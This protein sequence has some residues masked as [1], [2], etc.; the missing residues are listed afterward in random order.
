MCTI[1]GEA[2]RPASHSKGTREQIQCEKSTKENVTSGIISG[3]VMQNRKIGSKVK[4]IGEI[5]VFFFLSFFW[6]QL[7][8]GVAVL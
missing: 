4:H 8:V 2:R 3:L 5:I 1:R 7:P 6:K